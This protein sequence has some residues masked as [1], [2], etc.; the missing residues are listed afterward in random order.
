[1]INTTA[2]LNDSEQPVKP[3]WKLFF[4]EDGAGDIRP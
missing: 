2:I 3:D 1:M 4:P